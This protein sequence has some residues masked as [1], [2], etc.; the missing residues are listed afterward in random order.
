MTKSESANYPF[1]AW[2]SRF[3]ALSLLSRGQSWGGSVLLGPFEQWSQFQGRQLF[4]RS[5]ARANGQVHPQL[6]R[7]KYHRLERVISN[8][9]R[10]QALVHVL[11]TDFGKLP[12]LFQNI[13]PVERP[14]DIRLHGRLELLRA[15]MIRART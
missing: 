8:A 12:R 3:L 14:K 15:K 4:G 10:V 6:G 9:D 1:W 13:K 2:H 7:L 11:N 5:W